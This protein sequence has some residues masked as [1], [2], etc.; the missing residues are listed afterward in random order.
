[1]AD[2][3]AWSK[4]MT[5]GDEPSSLLELLAAGRPSWYRDGL[6]REYADVAFF[7]ELGASTAPAKAVCADCLVQPEC[8]EYALADP[9]LLGVW[10]GT[11]ARERGQ[12]RRGRIRP[13]AA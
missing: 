13:D 6:C 9:H 4:L 10:G 7:T 8:L 1:M 12:L 2:L 3:G 11:S 5:P